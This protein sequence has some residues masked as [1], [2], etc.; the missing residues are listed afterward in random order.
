MTGRG[1]GDR[2]WEDMKRKLE[3]L[4]QRMGDWER[5]GCQ[6]TTSGSGRSGKR[7]SVKGEGVRGESGKDKSKPETT[8]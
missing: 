7:K 6:F 5:N 1:Q 4:E 2:L 8:E 3:V